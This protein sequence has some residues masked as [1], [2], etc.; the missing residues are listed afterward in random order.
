MSSIAS[1]LQKKHLEVEHKEYANQNDLDELEETEIQVFFG[2]AEEAAVGEEKEKNMSLLEGL[3]RY[4]KA[5]GWCLVLSTGLIMEGYDTAILNSLYAL[6][7]FAQTFGEYNE[8]TSS[9][10]I[11]ARW[12]VG[13]SM[14][15]YCGEM[16]GLQFTGILADH[17]GNRWT[18]IGGSF[19]LLGFNFILY[20]AN[21]LTMI[22]IGQILCGIPWGSFQTLC[23]SYASE[24][25]PLVLRY[26]LT[27][28]NN[29]CWVF[30]QLIAS[31][32][33]KASQQQYAASSLGYKLPFALQW[34]WPVPL[35]VGIYLAPESPWWL[36]RKGK[37][38][39]A[40][41]STERVLSLPA[42]EKED[43]AGIMVKKIRMT[44]EKEKMKTS[45]DDSYRNC[46]KGV[47]AR[48]TR[49]ACITWMVQNLTG[50][51]LV[52]YSTYFYEKAGL[53]TSYAFTFSIIQYVLGIVG[54]MISWFLSSKVGRFK[55]IF[56][57]MLSQ[58]IIL[59]ITGGLGCSD[60][61][62]A[63]WGAGSMLLVLNFVYDTG[64]GPVVYCVVAEIPTDKLRTKT[65]V[66]ARN[67]YN[68][69]SIV[70]SIWTPYMLNS[71][72]W[73]WGAKTGFFWG[74]WTFFCV[75]WA[76]LDLP[77]TKDR[78]FAELDQLFYQKVSARKFSST[79]VQPFA[80]KTLLEDL[81]E[82][83]NNNLA[84]IEE[85]ISEVEP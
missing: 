44:I 25:C 55:I 54:T 37:M 43:M 51:A 32:V 50:C 41:N 46:F 11:P 79:F 72:E 22:A 3:R 56:W 16:I 70:N 2:D 1:E 76:Y 18:L 13:L 17:F 39:Q 47:N 65:V 31:G 19:L 4:P 36:I 80:R 42:P 28:Y 85:P 60:S 40:R 26:Y 27:T 8:S 57:G 15:V 48:R 77:E 21:S 33:M 38:E 24:I 30:G 7:I 69:V 20:F 53:D 35:I 63:S 75:I 83:D 9:W 14:C 58:M 5:A 64:L 66:L 59:F 68:L 62:T 6:P 82:K 45:T 73:D 81:R 78:T 71:T 61:K 23:V 34:I 67:A 84:V 52:G 74:V 12:Q 10:E 29:L 49:I